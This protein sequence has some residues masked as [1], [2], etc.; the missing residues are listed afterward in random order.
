MS[1]RKKQTEEKPEILTHPA[2]A[3]KGRFVKYVH[4][5]YILDDGNSFPNEPHYVIRDG[6]FVQE[7][8]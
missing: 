3:L 8:A 7:N 4:G 6:E 2:W 5:G 1:R